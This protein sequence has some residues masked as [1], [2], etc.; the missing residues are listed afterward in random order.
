MDHHQSVKQEMVSAEIDHIDHLKLVKQANTSADID[1]MDHLK[2]Y[3]QE[4]TSAEKDCIEVKIE[5]DPIETELGNY[6]YFFDFESDAFD[7]SRGSSVLSSELVVKQ[8]VKPA[9]ED[10]ND[11]KIEEHPI[12]YFNEPLI[13]FRK[14]NEHIR[15]HTGEKL[16]ACEHWP[17]WLQNVCQPFY[18]VLSFI[19]W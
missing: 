19:K 17:H 13:T 7:N 9:K 16:Y 1:H 14:T 8:E 18:N 6:H 10:H 2:L 3:K 4:N 12:N 15:T 11:I 5:K